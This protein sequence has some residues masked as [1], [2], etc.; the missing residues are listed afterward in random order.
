MMEWLNTDS[1]YAGV[2]SFFVMAALAFVPAMPIPVI[3]GIIGANFPFWLAL[4]IN[5][6]GTVTG[7]VGMFFVCRYYLQRWSRKQMLRYK[8]ST[9][10][11][12]LLDRNPFLAVLI[13]RLIPIMPSAAVNAIAGI[14]T[15]PLT[16]FYVATVLGKLPG[17]VT[18]TVAGGQLED[19]AVSS[20]LLVSIYLLFVVLVGR[21]VRK[22][23]S[24]TNNC[25][26]QKEPPN[27]I[28][29][30]VQPKNRG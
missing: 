26:P 17:M 28:D 8:A 30:N 20:I 1:P 14:T 25:P 11:L 23:P 19:S 4:L 18:F 2:A 10:F 24:N 9:G 27:H 12:A 7:C 15:M 29:K 16:I 22:N 6:G 13:A 21:K 5:V 3:A